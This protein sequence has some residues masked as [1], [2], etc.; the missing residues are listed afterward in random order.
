LKRFLLPLSI[1]LAITVLS[2]LFFGDLETDTLQL[3]TELK[4]S[5]LLFGALSSLVLMLDILLPVPS[6]IVLFLNGLVLGLIPGFLLSFS[7]LLLSSVVGYWIGRWATLGQGAMPDPRADALLDRF[8]PYAILISRGIPVLAESICFLCGYNRF[9]I[10]RYLWLNTLGYL[11]I[12]ALYSWLGQWGSEGDAFFTALFASG[13]V[14]VL[15]GVLG[16]R[17]S[18]GTKRIIA[19]PPKAFGSETPDK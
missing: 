5:P 13:L 9:P 10:R 17:L 18:R 8:G 4:S 14:A 7:A 19:P 11:P 6:G 16:K 12:A 15:F 2:F 1:L 3:L